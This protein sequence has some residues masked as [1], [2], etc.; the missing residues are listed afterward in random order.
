VYGT[1]TIVVPRSS[2]VYCGLHPIIYY[3]WF[4]TCEICRIG[5]R[6][7]MHPLIDRLGETGKNAAQSEVKH[8]CEYLSTEL[9]K[10]VLESNY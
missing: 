8:L 6:Y 3:Y 7:T 2:V 4:A 5:Y 1:G 10:Y 9:L